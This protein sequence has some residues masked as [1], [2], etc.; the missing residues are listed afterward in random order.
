MGDDL[1]S[2][3]MVFVRGGWVMGINATGHLISA[4]AI[5][6]F[7]FNGDATRERIL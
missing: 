7:Y 6:E 5:N 3:F 1:P 2:V 4:V